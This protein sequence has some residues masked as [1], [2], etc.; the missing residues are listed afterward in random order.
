MLADFDKLHNIRNYNGCE[1]G[2]ILYY[3]YNVIQDLVFLG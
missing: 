1:G 2:G 3:I